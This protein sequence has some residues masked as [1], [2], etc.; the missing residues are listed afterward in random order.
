LTNDNNFRIFV[1][2]AVS[3]L[4]TAQFDYLL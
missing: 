4:K 1:K 3:N 2:T